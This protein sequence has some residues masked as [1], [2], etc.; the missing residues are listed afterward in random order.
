MSHSSVDDSLE[1]NP[2]SFLILITSGSS[3]VEEEEQ[4]N[5]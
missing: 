1:K 4:E 3:E 2:V 5:E